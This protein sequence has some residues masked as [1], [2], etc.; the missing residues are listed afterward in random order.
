MTDARVQLFHVLFQCLR[1]GFVSTTSA[2]MLKII[3][4]AAVYRPDYEVLSLFALCDDGSTW[5]LDNP[6]LHDWAG[7]GT[8][9]KLPSVPDPCQPA[10][11]QS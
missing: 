7:R 5:I 9:H 1:R 2:L 8:W 11:Q 6:D 3:Q 4:I 10:G